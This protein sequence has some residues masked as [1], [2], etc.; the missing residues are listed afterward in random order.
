MFI[1]KRC[2]CSSKSCQCSLPKKE[3]EQLGK[4]LS[5]LSTQSRLEIL[6][7]LNEKPHCVCDLIYHT[8]LSQS[9]ISHHLA[10]LARA[11]LAKGKREGK[12]V[13]YYLTAKGKKFLK[14]LAVLNEKGGEKQNE[15]Q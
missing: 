12:Y 1:S 5:L 13:D 14:A 2:H 6:F 11:G 9:L 8:N 15:E 3:T 4:D 7:F 10:D